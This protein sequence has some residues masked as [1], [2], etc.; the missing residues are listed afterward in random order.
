MEEKKTEK[1]PKK[2]KKKT[3]RKNPDCSFVRLLLYHHYDENMEHGKNNETRR[4]YP[5]LLVPLFS[6]CHCFIIL[7]KT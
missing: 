6:Y 1:N 3:N 5:F 4:K 7:V 2:N